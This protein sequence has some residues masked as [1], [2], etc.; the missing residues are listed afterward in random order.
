MSLLSAHGVCRLYARAALVGARQTRQALDTVSINIDAGE[1]IA[2]LGRSGCGKSTLARILA[3]LETPDSGEVRF[4]GCPLASLRRQER[5]T[6]R[7]SVQMVF[8]DS[9]S[10]VDPRRTI[11]ESLAEPLRHLLGLDGRAC[12]KRTGDLLLRVGLEPRDAAKLPQQMSGGQLQR[13]CIARALAPEPR[14]VILDEAVS[15]VDLHLQL[16]LLA[17]FEALRRDM[18]VAYLFVTHDLRLAERFSSRIVVM[19]EGRVCEEAAVMRP[20][21]LTTPAGKALQDAILPAMPARRGLFYSA[22]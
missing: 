18:N 3:G 10:A 1:T 14:L 5:T 15:N 4:N 19:D 12:M 13:V 22:C 16:Q 20:L 9:F 6:F 2:L 21:Q 11:G 7:R 8:Q 17:L